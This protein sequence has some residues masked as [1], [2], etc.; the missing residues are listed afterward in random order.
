MLL[1]ATPHSGQTEE[2]QSLIG[3]LDPE[4]EHYELQT[5]AER[6]KLSRYFVQRRRADIN[7][8]LGGES[9]FPSRIQLE[10]D[11]YAVAPEYRSLLNDLINYIKS[12]VSKMNMS[13]KRK[14][15]YLYWERGVLLL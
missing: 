15:R 9:V 6:E 12:G 14:Q 10:D 11:E 7:H 4:F 8:Y 3:L 2:F 5:P 1:T 13:D